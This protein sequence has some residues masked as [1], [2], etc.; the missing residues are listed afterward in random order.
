MG[1]KRQIDEPSLAFDFIGDIFDIFAEYIFYL[2]RESVSYPQAK[3]NL[4]DIVNN[5]GFTFLLSFLFVDKKLGWIGG[6]APIDIFKCDI[7][8]TTI[9]NLYREDTVCHAGVDI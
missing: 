6:F 4:R 7:T 5:S 9:L 2:Q 3:Y 8:L 1:L